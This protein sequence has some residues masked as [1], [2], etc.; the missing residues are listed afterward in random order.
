[1]KS[2]LTISASAVL[3]LAMHCSLYAQSPSAAPPASANQPSAG[4]VNDWLRQQSPPFSAWDL[5]G[6]FRA[7]FEHREHFAATGVPGAVDFRETGG[8]SDNTYLLLREKIHLGY[9]PCACFSVYAEARDSTANHDDRE[10]SPDADRL[11]LHQA[12][13][14]LGDA[15][16]FPLTAKLGRQE[17]AYG[18]ER[19]IGVSDWSNVERVF[20]AAKLRFENNDFWVDAFVSRVVLVDDHNFNEAND[21]DFFSGLYASTRTWVPKQETQIYF[22]ARNVG[23]GSPAAIGPGLPTSLT[24]ASPRDIYTLGLHVKSLPGQLGGWDYEADLAGQLGRFKFSATAPS[25]DHQ[26]LM[27]RVTVGHTWTKSFGAPRVGLEYDYASGDSNSTD[28]KHGTFDSLFPTSHRPFGYMDFVSAQNIHS[29]RLSAAIKPVNKLTVTADYHAFW[30]ADNHDFFYQ[31][32]LAPRTTGGYGTKPG[33]GNFVGSEVD[34]VGT[35]AFKPYAIAQAG[36]GHF[37]IGNY[38]RNSLAGSGG[39]TDADFV[40]VQTVFNF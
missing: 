7:R 34:L 36:Y 4:L 17:M 25:L 14:I 3:A 24:G 5:G 27:A 9:S 16:Q 30:L 29:A 40:Y 6:Q 33:A 26:A 37:F 22:L 15:R 12:Y 20:D 2:K 32:N 35:Y 1:M 10:P 21:Y 11:D 13:V 28:A 39:A 8:N 23:T 38:V 31:A 19:F 18:D